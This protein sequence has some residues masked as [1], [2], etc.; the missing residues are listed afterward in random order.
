[1]KLRLLPFGALLLLSASFVS[2]VTIDWEV[3]N[4]FRLFANQADVTRF[5]SL[6][7]ANANVQAPGGGYIPPQTAWLP[8]ER[9]YR[10]EY[11]FPSDWVIRPIA[12]GRSTGDRCEWAV[13]N[14]SL[15]GVAP[16]DT[17]LNVNVHGSDHQLALRVNGGAWEVKSIHIGDL[18]ILGLGDSFSAGQGVP[19]VM[20]DF[21]VRYD[22]DDRLQAGKVV[23]AQWTDTE[24][25]RSLYS[26]QSLAAMKLSEENSHQSVTFL[27]FACSGAV[28]GY[29]ENFGDADERK[30][31]D[32]NSVKLQIGQAAHALCLDDNKDA[33]CKNGA[34]APD[35]ILMTVGG[36]DLGFVPTIMDAIKSTIC[37]VNPNNPQDF[38]PSSSKLKER[39][40][41]M[42]DPD[43]LQKA[44]D[45]MKQ[46]IDRRLRPRKVLIAGYLNPVIA[47]VFTNRAGEDDPAYCIYTTDKRHDVN[48][49]PLRPFFR[50][51]IPVFEA[52]QREMICLHDHY[53]RPLNAR[54]QELASTN[55]WEYIPVQDGKTKA[56]VVPGYCVAGDGP[57]AA[58]FNTVEDAQGRSGTDG[59][60]H[61]NLRGY[62]AYRDDALPVLERVTSEMKP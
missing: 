52:K 5:N 31:V 61:P 20:K 7:R 26:W 56:T 6:T 39:I 3:Q 12:P 38:R 42:Q 29:N 47:A 50:F 45:Q 57:R 48:G 13:D 25:R 18:L 43:K 49:R 41:A 14:V 23:P 17:H 11:P 1:M 21:T 55:G 9:R 53:V 27:S 44:F 22:N 54:L 58:H 51:Q 8:L 19:N 2:A 33:A 32:S 62:I 36:N 10:D 37:S 30:K 40:S 4:R 35:V 46:D 28:T 15:G 16:C 59:A 34:R 24:C 60:M